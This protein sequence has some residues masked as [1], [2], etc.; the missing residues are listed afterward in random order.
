VATFM[1]DGPAQRAEGRHSSEKRAAIAIGQLRQ[2]RRYTYL[3][4]TIVRFVTISFIRKAWWSSPATR[5]LRM[6]ASHLRGAAALYVL[7]RYVPSQV[8]GKRSV[9]TCLA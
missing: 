5:A 7:G 2:R 4:R 9:T 3:S 1:L 8:S 6:R